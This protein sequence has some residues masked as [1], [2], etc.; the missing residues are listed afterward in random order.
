MATTHEDSSGGGRVT[1]HTSSTAETIDDTEE[2]EEEEEDIYVSDQQQ[3]AAPPKAS[4]AAA[5]AAAVRA[6]RAA[7]LTRRTRTQQQAALL[8]HSNKENASPL[9]VVLE[10]KPA[11]GPPAA[12][13]PGAGAAA[14]PLRSPL[15]DLQASQS[16][17]SGY[18]SAGGAVNKPAMPAAQLK[19][20]AQ[21]GPPKQQLVG[22]EQQLSPVLGLTSP[23]PAGT[24]ISTIMMQQPVA[25]A[26]YGA[27]PTSRSGRQLPRGPG[28][29]RMR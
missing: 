4:F 5:A 15:Q 24:I 9:G 27:L 26:G 29:A 17:N 23:L 14:M 19:P 8:P 18:F 22:Q 12:A 21:Q 10:D 20:A 3:Q 1:S 13:A 25:A 16:H 28:V 7:A 2:E 11:V 6:G